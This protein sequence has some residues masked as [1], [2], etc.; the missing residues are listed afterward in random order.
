MSK[1]ELV[2]NSESTPKPHT[3]DTVK[4]TFRTNN[5]NNRKPSIPNPA[6]PQKANVIKLVPE[7]PSIIMNRNKAISESQAKAKPMY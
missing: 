2:L 5:F 4:E 1:S 6:N 3:V 7:Q